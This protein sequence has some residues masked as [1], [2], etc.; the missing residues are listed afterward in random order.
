ML[1]AWQAQNALLC[2]PHPLT[3]EMTAFKPPDGC[4]LISH[5][6]VPEAQGDLWVWPHAGTPL[7]SKG[8]TTFPPEPGLSKILGD[9]W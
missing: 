1:S 4:F 3:A 7:S 2:L 9:F 5:S 8:I 6:L